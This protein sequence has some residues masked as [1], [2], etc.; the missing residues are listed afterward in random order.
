M[1]EKYMSLQELIES[2]EEID[3]LDIVIINKDECSEIYEGYDIEYINEA[4]L[5][6]LVKY[7]NVRYEKRGRRTR[8]I[9][10]VT[11]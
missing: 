9:L 10:E 4:T 5:K 3:D 8:R 7:S 6:L 2:E 11:V 1:N